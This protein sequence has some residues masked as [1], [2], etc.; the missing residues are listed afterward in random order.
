MGTLAH[1]LCL[2]SRAFRGVPG[3]VGVLLLYDSPNDICR[4]IDSQSLIELMTVDVDIIHK[5]KNF[6][7]ANVGSVKKRAQKQ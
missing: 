5:T 2:Q 6:C 3:T 1:Y 7:I 4:I